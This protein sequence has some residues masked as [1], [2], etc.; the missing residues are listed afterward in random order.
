ML[1][2]ENENHDQS[3]SFRFTSFQNQV[4]LM[5]EIRIFDILIFKKYIQDK[6]ILN[7]IAN[8]CIILIKLKRMKICY[9]FESKY[10]EQNVEDCT[11]FDKPCF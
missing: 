2:H 3:C 8:K 7:I 5:F 1:V 6:V 10:V 11:H 4:L 9:Y